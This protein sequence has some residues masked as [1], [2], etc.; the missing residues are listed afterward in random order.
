M[1]ARLRDWAKVGEEEDFTVAIKAHVGGA[2]HTPEDCAWLALQAE[3]PRVKC[4][5]DYSHFQ[6]RGIDLAESVRTLIPRTAFLH[7]K[8]AT[9]DASRFQFLLPGEG[10]T[11]YVQLLKLVAASGYRGDVVVEVSGQVFS[12]PDYRPLDAARRCY[13]TLAPAFERAGVQRK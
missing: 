4:V 12:K 1:A 7:V 2:L 9:G 5:Y 6:L 10:E 3:N 11:D 13:E 8:D